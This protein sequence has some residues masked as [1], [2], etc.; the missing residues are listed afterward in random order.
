MKKWMVCIDIFNIFVWLTIAIL[1]IIVAGEVS[2]FIFICAVIIII[3]Y[4]SI[5]IMNKM[6]DM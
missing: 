4:A 2:I 3:T 6:Q 5:N 1:Q